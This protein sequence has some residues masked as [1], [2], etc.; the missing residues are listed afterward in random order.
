MRGMSLDVYLESLEPVTVFDSN[1]THN[2][3]EMADKVGLYYALWYPEEI[4][5]EKAG[6]LIW[7]L[8][9]GLHNLRK[10]P[11]QMKKLNPKN[12]W[13]NYD[14]FVCFVDDYLRACQKHPNA[15]IGISR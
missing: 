11:E 9:T 12:G 13:G 15:K 10:N 5:F 1:I 8:K 14:S 6:D 3:T 7:V 4:G 2:L